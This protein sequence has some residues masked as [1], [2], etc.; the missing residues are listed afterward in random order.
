[1]KK[2]EW[3]AEWF[4]TSYYHTLYQHR[5][6]PEAKEF[7]ERLVAHLSLKP[8]TKVLDL[9]CGKGRHSIYLN[10]MGFQVT[11]ADLSSNSITIAKE[12][13]NETL[14]ELYSAIR[15]LSE[16]DRAII[17]LYLEEKTY[18]EIAEITGSNTNNIG[19]RIN[20]IKERLK[21]LL[22]GKIN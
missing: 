1:M 18:N 16:V 11:G 19:V 15:H 6:D 14:N 2:A 13:E 22:D 4:D 10:Q 17:L 3:F 12:F 5:N 21:T 7:I 8:G 20:R 9:A